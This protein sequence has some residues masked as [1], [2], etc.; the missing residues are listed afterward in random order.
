METKGLTPITLAHPTAFISK[1]AKIGAGSQIMAGSIIAP[2]VEIGQ[3]CII[4]TNATVYHESFLESIASS[5]I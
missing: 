2:E 1:N 4:N 3:D 5:S